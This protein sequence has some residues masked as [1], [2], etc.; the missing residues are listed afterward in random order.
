[1]KL[2]RWMMFVAMVMVVSVL[3]V[4]V[5]AQ[6]YDKWVG[7]TSDWFTASNWAMEGIVPTSATEI[8]FYGPSAWPNQP[9]I[10]A[11][12]AVA[13]DF[14]M[15]SDVNFPVTISGTGTLT[16]YGMGGALNLGSYMANVT[17]D[18]PLNISNSSSAPR[19]L[20]N[21]G[22]T[23]AITHGVTFTGASD[24]VAGTNQQ[25]V[26]GGTVLLA[27][28][29]SGT[30]NWDVYGGSTLLVTN[31]SGSATG[32]G[33]I[34]LYHGTT[35]YATLAGT[36]CVGTGEHNLQNWGAI[37]PGNGAVGTLTAN[38]GDIEF[39]DGSLLYIRAS[40]A[41]LSKLVITGGLT[42]GTDVGYNN[43]L[44]VAGTMSAAGTCITYGGTR[45]GTF[46]NTNLPSGY[47]VDYSV[48]GQVSVVPAGVPSAP[49]NLAATPRSNSRIDLTWTDNSTNETSFKIERKT[50]SAGTW[51]QI[52]TVG[53]S[54]T[55]Y[56]NTGL[57]ASTA[58]YYRVR[59][60]NA[61]GDSVPSPEA[62][63]TTFVASAPAAP[64]N[65]TA[66]AASSTQIT[67]FWTDNSSNE[68]GFKIERKTGTAGTYAQVGT[69][70]V[71]V[72]TYLNT[73]LSP[74][75]LYY[76]R[77]RATNDVGD[78]GYSNEAYATTQTPGLPAAP[79]N[80]SATA[81]SSGEIDLVWMD[82]ASDETGFKIERKTGSAGTYAQL[83]TVGA[84]VTAYPDTGLPA[85]TTYYYRVRATNA[86]GDSEYCAEAYTTTWAAQYNF[87]LGT[88]ADWHTPAN[89]TDYRPD[90]ARAQLDP[91]RQPRSLH[92]RE[93]PILRDRDAD[94]QRAGLRVGRTLSA[95]EPRHRDDL[96]SDA[97]ALY[98]G[99]RPGVRRAERRPR[100]GHTETRCVQHHGG[101]LRG[102]P[103]H[104]VGHQHHRVSDR[105]RLYLPLQFQRQSDRQRNRRYRRQ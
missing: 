7:T 56:Q 12:N 83:G 71:N 14:Q 2:A 86:L 28:A 27:A 47:S 42:L 46:K 59:A 50:G 74:S 62:N 79:S 30:A 94:R 63:A 19:L 32:S 29:G 9:A 89:W 16:L 33:T 18:C 67:L 49:F 34:N 15:G 75:T 105:E 24:I 37:D 8:L 45:T 13:A 5:P 36:G 99:E 77:V 31:P 48:P 91:Q 26:V 10:G 102:G 60:S 80:L 43:T 39:Y 90:S 53:A 95:G 52:G 100:H 22:T 25:D 17:I 92:L 70:G 6:A 93:S 20:A 81:K 87:W 4:A 11:S 98:L 40:G 38:V 84:N 101:I 66:L 96:A 21:A 41:Q 104:A 57:T 51:S 78:S 61:N 103:G 68:H 72:T 23:F 85:S 88:T 76:Y 65:L 35:Y 55:A 54:V 58:Y 69:V 1:M 3:G 73:G 64:S 82:N 44:T 97:G